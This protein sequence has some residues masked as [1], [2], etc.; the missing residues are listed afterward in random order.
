[1]L[2]LYQILHE[3]KETIHGHVPLSAYSSNVW[4][5]SH[6]KTVM[7]TLPNN[8]FHHIML[9]TKLCNKSIKYIS[10]NTQQLLCIVTDIFYTFIT[11]NTTGW[12]MSK[13]LCKIKK[14]CI[15][16]YVPI[17]LFSE[18]FW[19]RQIERLHYITLQW[20]FWCRLAN[21]ILTRH[22]KRALFRNFIRICKLRI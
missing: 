3:T 12:N 17:L 8:D 21:K 7:W 10:H 16:G 13:K 22:L 6:S 9:Y 1:M 5:D 2:N 4:C 11:A 14:A 18:P 19:G 15:L 20:Q